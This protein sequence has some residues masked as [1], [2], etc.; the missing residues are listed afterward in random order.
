ML[1]VGGDIEAEPGGL[2]GSVD[3]APNDLL[4]LIHFSNV[5]VLVAPSRNLAIIVN[6]NW[7]SKEFGSEDLY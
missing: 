3:L 5:S 6:A 2:D 7:R 4:V 1:L